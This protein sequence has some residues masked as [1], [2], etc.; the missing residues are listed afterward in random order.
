MTVAVTAELRAMI[1]LFRKLRHSSLSVKSLW[2][3]RKEKPVHR[4]LVESLNEDTI[5]ITRGRKRNIMVITKTSW[6]KE[7]A[8]L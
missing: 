8:F 2:Y 6:E 4:M 5:R 7:N 3:H 1:I